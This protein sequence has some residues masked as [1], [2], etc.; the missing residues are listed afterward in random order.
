MVDSED[1]L[2]ARVWWSVKESNFYDIESRSM[3]SRFFDQWKERR[4]EFPQS[5]QE[6]GVDPPEKAVP[7][8]RVTTDKSVS[9]A[10]LSAVDS[11]KALAQRRKRLYDAYVEAGF[12]EPQALELCCKEG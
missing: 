10:S 7:R 5:L 3:G 6:L 1:A 9:L 11:I 4:A 2:P 8:R 12:T